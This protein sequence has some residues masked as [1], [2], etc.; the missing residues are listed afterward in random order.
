MKVD[1]GCHCGNIR[2]EVCRVDPATVAICHCTDCQTLSGSAFRTVVPTKE[3]SFEYCCQAC[4]RSTSRPVKVV[5][6]GSRRSAP[7]CGTPID[8][9]PVGDGAKSGEFARRHCSPAR[10][11]GPD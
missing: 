3:G 5:T 1:G 4:R 2:Y 9:G 8:S 6:G 7:I 10:S 11:D